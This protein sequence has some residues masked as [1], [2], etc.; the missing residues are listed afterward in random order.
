MILLPPLWVGEAGAAE[1]AGVAVG[2]A[3]QI[4]RHSSRHTIVTA[5]ALVTVAAVLLSLTVS[6]VAG[7]VWTMIG[8]FVVV[9]RV[10]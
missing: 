3:V 4:R 2:N 5:L 8:Y 1:S 7:L 10:L 6:V 9:V